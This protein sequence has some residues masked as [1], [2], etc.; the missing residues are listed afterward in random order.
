MA[1]V[2]ITATQLSKMT[3]AV[4]TQG[5]GTAIVEANTNKVLYPKDGQLLLVV[6]SDHADTALTFAAGFGVEA[7]QGSTTCEVGSGIQHLIV[8]GDSARYK[9]ADGYVSWTYAT[10]SAGYVRAFKLPL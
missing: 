8:I 4:I 10:N 5:A 9:D 2:A 3:G 7:G 1:T 6:D